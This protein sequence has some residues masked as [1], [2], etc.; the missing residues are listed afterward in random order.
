VLLN[1]GPS[2]DPNENV[3]FD[4]PRLARKAAPES[5]PHASG[6]RQFTASVRAGLSS[7][8]MAIVPSQR[9][10]NRSAPQTSAGRR[11]VSDGHKTQYWLTTRGRV[12]T[13]T[14]GGSGGAS[15]HLVTG[16]TRWTQTSVLHSDGV[17]Q[18]TRA[19]ALV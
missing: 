16:A 5:E 1:G 8:V 9:T 11:G 6:G 2:Y 3:S 18:G 12:S 14:V 10:L 13:G 7:V 19:Y 4:I 15:A 17:Q